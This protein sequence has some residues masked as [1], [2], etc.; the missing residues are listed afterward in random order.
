[1]AVVSMRIL[2]PSAFITI[3][4]WLL[5]TEPFGSFAQNDVD[6]LRAIRSSLEDPLGYLGS[7]DFS[8][9]S[10]T[11]ICK[12]IG[13]E[14]WHEDDNNILNIRLPD[15]GLK[16]GFP[17]GIAGCRSLTGLDLSRNSI[18]GNIPYNVSK[19]IG[20]VTSLDLSSN[21]LSGEIPVDLANCSFLNVLRLDSN[22]LTGQIP[23]QLSQLSR[24]K[25]FSVANNRLSGQV[26]TFANANITAES[27]AN[28]PGLCG[29]PLSPCSGRS[30]ANHN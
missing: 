11:S 5:L 21:Q 19:L 26:P 24:L 14:C 18:T 6:C 28:N 20:F 3:L 1:M 25:T 27:Y 2:S 4:V 10:R 12:F 13:I 17:Q 23:L 16:G 22:Q 29:G 9:S 15:M 7:W 30:K 8:N